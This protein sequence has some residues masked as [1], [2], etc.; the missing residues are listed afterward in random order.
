[1]MNTVQNVPSS[2]SRDSLCFVSSTSDGRRF[3]SSCEIGIDLHFTFWDFVLCVFGL[4]GVLCLASCA[5]GESIFS[6]NWP[7]CDLLTEGSRSEIDNLETS[8]RMSFRDSV[9]DAGGI[10]ER[11]CMRPTG[12]LT[13]RFKRTRFC[14]I[15]MHKNVMKNAYWDLELLWIVSCYFSFVFYEDVLRYLK[16]RATLL[17][18]RAH[19][20]EVC[21]TA[22]DFNRCESSRALQ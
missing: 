4:G 9:G 7:L 14:T 5:D 6:V 13:D 3:S 17:F 21:F 19:R 12:G 18:P 16:Y 11:S 15:C 1:M 8:R 2:T 10:D 22:F 20:N